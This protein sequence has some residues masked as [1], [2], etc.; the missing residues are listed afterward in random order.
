MPI[1]RYE[2]ML[3][4]NRALGSGTWVAEPKLDGWRALVYVD[5]G[6]CVRTRKGRVV[7]ENVP[8]LAGVVDAVP[9]GTVL[10]GELVAGQGR[11]TD[12]YRLGP[13]MMARRRRAALTF[14][15]FDVLHVAGED[16]TF[17]PWAKRRHLLEVRTDAPYTPGQR[18]A[19]W[20]KLKT[21]EWKHLHAPLR[22]ER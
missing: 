15:A 16:M 20:V 10:D 3:A 18:S 5:D 2:P 14:V 19:A 9:D 7:T 1:A 13:Q 8:E 4:T 11:A 22:H 6:L 21:S 12:F 17:L